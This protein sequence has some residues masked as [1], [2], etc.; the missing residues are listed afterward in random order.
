MIYHVE[1]YVEKYVEKHVEKHVEKY[2]HVLFYVPNSF[3]LIWHV[4]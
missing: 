4:E 1:K 2:K 3:E